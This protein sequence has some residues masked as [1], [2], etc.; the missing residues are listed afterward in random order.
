M[1]GQRRKRALWKET[2]TRK[3]GEG[4]G[5]RAAKAPAHAH[6]TLPPPLPHRPAR[7]SQQSRLCSLGQPAR[8]RARAARTAAHLLLTGLCFPEPDSTTLSRPSVRR[9]GLPQRDC[10]VHRNSRGGG[11]EMA[12]TAAPGGG[13]RA[14]ACVLG[15]R[16]CEGAGGGGQRP[17]AGLG[18]GSRAVLATHSCSSL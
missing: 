8:S 7:A 6:T 12:P 9:S 10:G 11:G 14:Y 16:G 5:P 4:R 15:Q 2:R 18:R 1:L 17:P 13:A 3:T